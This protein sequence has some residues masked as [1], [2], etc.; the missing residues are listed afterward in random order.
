MSCVEVKV[1]EERLGQKRP[2]GKRRKKKVKLIRLGRAQA[3]KY[4]K[5]VGSNYQGICLTV[6]GVL[7]LSVKSDTQS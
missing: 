3:G 2:R 7:V 4:L 1:S 5:W 6:L